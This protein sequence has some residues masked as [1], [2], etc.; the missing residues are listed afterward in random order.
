MKRALS[1]ESD[2]PPQANGRMITMR[3]GLTKRRQQ[4]GGR[5]GRLPD[6]R[7]YR[8][9][10][11]TVPPAADHVGRVGDIYFD[12]TDATVYFR[13]FGAAWRP[14][15]GRCTPPIFL[16]EHPLYLNRHLWFGRQGTCDGPRWLSASELLTHGVDAKEGIPGGEL[17]TLLRKEST[18]VTGLQTVKHESKPETGGQR[19][20]KKEEDES[21]IAISATEKSIDDMRAAVEKNKESLAEADRTISRLERQAIAKDEELET[22]HQ[23]YRREL[24]ALEHRTRESMAAKEAETHDT[25]LRVEAQAIA[26]DRELETVH[27]TYRRETQ[28]LGHR[29]RESMAAKEAETH[30]TLSRME[31]QAASQLEA[32]RQTHREEIQ[33]LEQRTQAS[34]AAKETVLQN[35]LS[36]VEMESAA[37]LESVRQT[38]RK[39]MRGGPSMAAKEAEIE[40]IHR[41]LRIA[42]EHATDAIW[43]LQKDVEAGNQRARMQDEELHQLR[44]RVC[45]GQI[46]PGVTA[47]IHRPATQPS[48]PQR[49]DPSSGFTGIRWKTSQ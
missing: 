47:Q 46:C 49:G 3:G 15:N 18:F 35:A 40:N 44:N 30:N 28:A 11:G 45:D 19:S 37:Q 2:S 26:K 10:L 13:D 36:R 42:N 25:L 33:A 7:T 1:T 6:G 38:L 41:L 4:R 12:T 48:A 8:Q 24:Q 17:S 29:T 9:T 22:V 31:A 32:V 5:P 14:W 27:Q 16:P 20:T 21:S 34:M 43:R 39:G 23:T